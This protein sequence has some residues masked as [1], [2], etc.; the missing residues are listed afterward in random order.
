MAMVETNGD[1]HPFASSMASSEQAENVY[2]HTRVEKNDVDFEAE[3][4]D[5]ADFKA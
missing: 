1:E 4:I 2:R 5:E 3:E